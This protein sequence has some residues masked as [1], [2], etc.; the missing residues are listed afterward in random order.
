[1]TSADFL[2]KDNA[3]TF[4][5]ILKSVSESLRTQMNAEHL[6]QIFSYNVS[7]QMN[8]LLRLVPL[9]LKGLAMRYIYLQSAHANTSTITNVGN[10]VIDEIYKPYIDTFHAFLTIST[11]QHIKGTVLSYDDTLI[12]TFSYNLVDPSIQRRFFRKLADDGLHIEIES[13]GVH[14]V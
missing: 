11:C 3:H 8:P 10:I 1:M 4:E 5:D 2:P 13:N 14:Y 12:F 9:P 7:N 6:E